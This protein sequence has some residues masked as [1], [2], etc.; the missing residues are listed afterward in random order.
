MSS[1][2]V[3]GLTLDQHR[4]VSRLA[5]DARYNVRSADAVP[6]RVRQYRP[7]VRVI[8]L[9]DRTYDSRTFERLPYF[10]FEPQRTVYT[11]QFVGSALSGYVALTISGQRFVLECRRETLSDIETA[12]PGLRATV[13]PGYWELDFG[14]PTYSDGISVEISA[15]TTD[16]NTSIC[17]LFDDLDS[18]VFSGATIVRREGWVT[19]IDETELPAVAR[20]PVRDCI[21]Y[22]NG[23]VGAGAIGIVA[24]TWDAGFLAIAWQCRTW[25]WAT[26]YV[27]SDDPLFHPPGEDPDG[28]GGTGGG[29]PTGPETPPDL[30]ELP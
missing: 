1:E 19:S 17:A 26:G 22:E 15:I 11:I 30:P 14:V 10:V 16:E 29:G 6:P 28:G 7:P 18:A 4:Q 24:W 25:S 21:P 3:Y 12:V 23:S 8:A 13:L 5:L 20:T 27:Q 2:D 9:T